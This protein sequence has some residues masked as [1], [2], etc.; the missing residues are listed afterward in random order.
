MKILIIAIFSLFLV[1]GCVDQWSATA[2]D[3][4]PFHEAEL[5]CRAKAQA[6]ALHQL[7][8]DYDRDPGPAGFPADSRRDIENRETALCLKQKGFTLKRSW[9]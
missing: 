9:K 3:G 6:S 1:S 4:T 8:F 2:P 5:A 7:P